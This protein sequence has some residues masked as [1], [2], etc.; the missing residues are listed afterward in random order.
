MPLERLD[1]GDAGQFWHVQR[2]RP[3]ADELRGEG[4]AATGFDDPARFRFVPVQAH[5]L[6]VK[7]RVVVEAILL[8]D[9]LAVRQDFRRMRVF[10]GRH[11]AGFFK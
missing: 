11:V 8:A 7:Q 5:D 3:H 9:A 10:F 2:A 4:I 1:A 6:G